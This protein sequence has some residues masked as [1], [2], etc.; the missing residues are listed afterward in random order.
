MPEDGL[1]KALPGPALKAI[2]DV[3]GVRPDLGTAAGAL[4]P[5][6]AC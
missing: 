1:T 3:A 6:P 4:E 2:R 5:D